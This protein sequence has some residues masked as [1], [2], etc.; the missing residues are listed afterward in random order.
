MDN[1][2]YQFLY[3]ME[4]SEDDYEDNPYMPDMWQR[5]DDVYKSAQD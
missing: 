4:A 2:E 1:E 3:S 5:A